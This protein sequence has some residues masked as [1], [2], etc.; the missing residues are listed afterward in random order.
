MGDREIM[1]DKIIAAS[2]MALMLVG[3]CLLFGTIGIVIA[4][5]LRMVL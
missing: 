2:I 4:E 1:K 5:A 3:C